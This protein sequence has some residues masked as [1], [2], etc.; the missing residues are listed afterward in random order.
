MVRLAP[1][2]LPTGSIAFFTLIQTAPAPGDLQWWAQ[3]GALGLFT[4]FMILLYRQDHKTSEERL[5]K[6]NTRLADV[7][8]NDIEQRGRLI[9]ILE[10]LKKQH[11]CVYEK[12][13]TPKI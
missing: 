12:D 10:D 9:A 3:F 7:L 5:E 13:Q 4:G 2:L 6:M 11:F 8:D 1:Y